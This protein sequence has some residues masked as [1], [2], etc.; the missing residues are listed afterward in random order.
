[1]NLERSLVLNR[2]F[3]SLLGA[4]RFDDFR[5]ALKEQEEGA[6]PDGRARGFPPSTWPSSK[7]AASTPN[8]L[9]ETAIKAACLVPGWA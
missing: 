2:Y 7:T 3:H 8:D 5:R 6:G 4:E 9:S 1:M